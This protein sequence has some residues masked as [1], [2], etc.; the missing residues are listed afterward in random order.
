M[1]VAAGCATGDGPKSSSSAADQAARPREPGTVRVAG[2]VLKWI[3]ADK[4]R[5]YARAEPMIRQAAAQGADIVV[6]TECFLD[7]YAIRDKSIPIDDWRALGEE[8]PGGQY[9]RRLHDLA[10][11]LDIYLVAGMVEREGERTH[12]AAVLIGPDGRLIGKYR[13]QRLGHEVPRNTPGTESPVFDTPF[14]KVGLMICAD[15]RYPEVISRLGEQGVDLMICPSGGM[16]GPVKN[17]FHLQARS[18]ENHAPVVFV[19]PI[20]FLVTGAD[21]TILDRRFAG[22]DMSLEL[23]RIDSPADSRLVA[24]YDLKLEN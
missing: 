16:W 2:I 13:K 20:E 1:L 15:R 14:G 18:R 6:T 5:N 11:E 24:L 19:H 7:G 10:D 22:R 4:D 23:D 17:D 9:L 21:G 3:T 12:N 8:I